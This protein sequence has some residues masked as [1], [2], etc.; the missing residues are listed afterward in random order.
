ML[1]IVIFLCVIIL[2]LSAKASEINIAPVT[3][4]SG[5]RALLNED[6]FLPI[7][8]IK[9][10]FKNSG[11]AYDPKDKNGLSF[12]VSSLLKEG[13]GNLSDI[14]YNE[15]LENLAINLEF[16]TDQDYLYVNIKT[17]TK[18]LDKALEL[19]NLSLTEANFEEKAIE[20]IKN[21]TKALIIKQNKD[22]QYIA[23]HN[24]YKTIFENHPYANPITGN[25]KSINSINKQDLVLFTKNN[26]AK[27]NM[28][29]AVSGDISSQILSQKLEKY[30]GNIQDKQSGQKTI[31]E[32][33]YIDSD[34]QI[35]INYPNQQTLIVV[36]SEGVL[37][38]SKDFYPNYVANYILGGGEFQSRL[39][40]ELREKRG[41][42]YSTNSAL[43][44]FNKA[45][46]LISFASTRSEETK[47]SVKIIENTIQDLARGNITKQELEDAKQYLIDSFALKLITNSNFTDYLLVMQLEDLGIDFLQKR[48]DYIRQVTL[49]QIND[50]VI[51]LLNKKKVMVLVGQD[52]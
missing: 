4:T 13:A 49:D 37:R 36:A 39:M 20:R 24:V 34:R 17:L 52:L 18:N 33:K 28:V 22:P 23:M 29:I 8:S 12:L 3:T 1:R 47:N 16:S 43:D 15:I 31:G 45:G 5:I 10:A 46:L 38:K 41:L 48:N 44:L 26:F 6:H 42:V 51:R 35:K 14:Q 50:S 7:I 40:K 30:L 32:V 19:L 27:N 21:Q 2:N 25:I 11:S 9:I